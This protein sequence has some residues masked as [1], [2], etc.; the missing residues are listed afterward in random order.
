MAHEDI[1]VHVS[2]IL[3][4][5]INLNI[6]EDAD[7]VINTSISASSETINLNLTEED[8][9]VINVSILNSQVTPV[10][11]TVFDPLFS[12][13]QTF[14]INGDLT[15]DG[16]IHCSQL[17]VDLVEIDPSGALTDQV[18]VFNGSKF[19]PATIPNGGGG[20]GGGGGTPLTVRYSAVVP[21]GSS[22]ATIQHDLGSTDVLVEVYDTLTG[23]SI[24]CGV[25]R[26]TSNTVTL[27]I[28]DPPQINQYKV[29]VFYPP[30]NIYT[31]GGGGG[32]STRFEYQQTTPSAQWSISH[33]LNGYPLVTVTDSSGGQVFGD[34]TYPSASQVLI[35]FTASFTGVASL[36]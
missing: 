3:P 33:T 25:Q 11:I 30:A 29:I 17:F 1:H 14:N 13:D 12:N 18:L 2:N 26:T 7:V 15:V 4:Q 23:N 24:F 28:D 19:V 9:V 36:I 10:Q 16:V 27:T 5:P 32:G 8:P 22:S 31:G 6:T 34:V 21:H 20:G 35:N